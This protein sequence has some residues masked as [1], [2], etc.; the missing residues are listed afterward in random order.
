MAWSKLPRIFIASCGVDALLADQIVERVG[1]G[2]A[3]TAKH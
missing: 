2:K 1:Q 3:D